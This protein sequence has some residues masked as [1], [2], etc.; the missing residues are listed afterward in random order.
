[1]RR[2]FILV[3]VLLVGAMPTGSGA[4][5]QVETHTTSL[6]RITSFDSQ[7]IMSRSGEVE[8]TETIT[9]VARGDQIE[10]GIYRDFPTQRGRYWYGP[11]RVAFEVLN[12][13]RDGQP[14]SWF[15]ERGPFVTRLYLGERERLLRRGRHTYTITYRTDRQVGF[16]TDYDQLR[17]NVTGNFWAFPIEHATAT[18]VPPGGAVISSSRAYTGLLGATDQ[19]AVTK[20]TVLGH[21]KAASSQ[22]LA[23]GEGLT[24]TVKLPAG[25]VRQPDIGQHISYMWR[26]GAPVWVGIIGLFIVVSYYGVVWTAHGRDPESG[27]IIPRYS[28]PENVGPAAC[29]YIL[30]MGWDAKGFTAAIVN[31]AAKG[32]VTITEFEQDKFKLTRTS[33]SAKQA[34]LTPGETAVAL[35]LFGERLWTSYI[36]RKE[37]HAITDSARKSLKRSLKEDFE[38]I[39]FFENKSLLIVGTALSALTLGAMA[40]VNESGLAMG[41]FALVLSLLAFA[42]YPLFLGIWT[43]WHRGEGGVIILSGGIATLL[44]A[45]IPIF[46]VLLQ[47][48]LSWLSM[49][50]VAQIALI[51]LVIFANMLFYHLLKSPSRLGRKVMDHIEGFRHYLQVA[52]KDRLNFHNPPDVTPEVFER[53]LPFAIALNVENEWGTQFDLALDRVGGQN[54]SDSSET[55][56]PTWFHSSYRGWSSPRSF[57]T[58]FTPT[59]GKSV[60][61]SLSPPGSGRGSGIGGGGFSGGGGG[62]SGGGGW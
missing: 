50:A 60:V 55:Y 18:I 40:T 9:V 3:S 61:S 24:V 57:A 31:L 37:H 59:F 8:V 44:A 32:F 33:A 12:V 20:Q 30:S 26:D 45:A 19:N 25:S 54:W 52:E 53:Y 28:P 5:A 49:D 38:S 46:K 41:V 2:A 27:T 14:E 36:F 17:W 10:R 22:T 56:E 58:E 21:A 35:K 16:L 39:Y 51:V 11:H 6:E 47:E 43:G 42:L 62:G 34:K 7:I 23:P 48:M 13:T 4:A 15:T 29:R 1:M